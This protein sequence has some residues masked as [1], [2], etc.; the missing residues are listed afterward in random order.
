MERNFFYFGQSLFLPKYIESQVYVEE[1]ISAVFFFSKDIYNAP[2]NQ[3]K[4][5]L[6]T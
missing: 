4:N 2:T 6:G 1:S 3:Q 5:V